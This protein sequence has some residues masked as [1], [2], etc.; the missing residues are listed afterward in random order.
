MKRIIQ[1]KCRSE[2]VESS[3]THCLPNWVI[4]LVM[5]VNHQKQG[6]SMTEEFFQKFSNFPLDLFDTCRILS[7]AIE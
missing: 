7:I 2:C 6:L 3:F 1:I 5:L 4:G